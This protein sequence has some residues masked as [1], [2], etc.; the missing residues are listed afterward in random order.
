MRL[1]SKVVGIIVLAVMFGGIYLTAGLGWWQ[2]AGGGR[3]AGNHNGA[4]ESP[5]EVTVLRGS[6]ISSDRRGITIAAADGQSLY[7]EL[8]NPR[9]NRSI[10]FAPQLGEQVTAQAFIPEGKTAYSAVTVTLDRTGQVYVFRDTLGQ[11]LWS[12][13]HAE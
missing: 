10:G 6:I 3:G 9:Y 12:G 2:T 7:I 1:N 13:N 11:P 5:P 4:G 8:G